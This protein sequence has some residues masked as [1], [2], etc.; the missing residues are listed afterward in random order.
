MVLIGLFLHNEDGLVR[1]I[2]DVLV[3]DVFE[4]HIK[5][6]LDIILGSARHFLNDFGPLVANA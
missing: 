3:L 1:S 4:H 6:I 2:L 5:S